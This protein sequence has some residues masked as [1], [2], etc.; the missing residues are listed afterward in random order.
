MRSPK[1]KIK[2]I[3]SSE[4]PRMRTQLDTSAKL[5]KALRFGR[6]SQ[7]WLLG[8]HPAPR[9]MLWNFPINKD[10][11]RQLTQSTC[12]EKNVITNKPVPLAKTKKM[13]S[14]NTMTRKRCFNIRSLCI[15]PSNICTISTRAPE[16]SKKQN[17]VFFATAYPKHISA[18]GWR[19]LGTHLYSLTSLPLKKNLMGSASLWVWTQL[20]FWLNL[21]A[22]RKESFPL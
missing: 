2:N 4:T 6:L 5:K 10:Q 1:Q 3:S 9:P 13:R 14:Q 20:I 11:H 17:N 19:D 15:Q 21:K 7:A 18:K 22:N 12:Q 16:Q 8:K